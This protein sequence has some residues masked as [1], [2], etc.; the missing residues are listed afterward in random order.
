[1]RSSPKSCHPS[2]NVMD[3]FDANDPW[4][5]Y[6]GRYRSGEWRSPIF[7][8]MVLADARRLGPGPAILDIGCGEGLDGS[9]ELQHS[10]AT[11]AGRFIGIEPDP[12]IKLADHFTETH[13]CPFEQAPMEAGSIDLSYAVMVLEHLPRPQFFWDR[14]FEVLADGGVFWGLTVDARHPFARFSLWADRLK[15][16]DVY[17]DFV[18]GRVSVSESGRY[19]NYPTYYRTNTPAQISQLTRAFRSSEYINF[20]RVG[21]WSPYL[22]R[23]LRSIVN[24]IDGLCVRRRRP[25]TLLAVRVVK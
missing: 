19:K 25:G 18:L 21:Q 17:L 13:R 12:T 15:I 11:V 1:M 20:S 9:V 22:P 24:K 3:A 4:A 2:H 23:P 6:I 14:L 8:D 16:K 7:R 5:P 10:I